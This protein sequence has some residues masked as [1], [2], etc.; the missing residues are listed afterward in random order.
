M[1]PLIRL[2]H[3]KKVTFSV[4]PCP[5]KC[6]SPSTHLNLVMIFGVVIFCWKLLVPVFCR[7]K[8]TNY[9]SDQSAAEFQILFLFSAQPNHWSLFLRACLTLRRVV[10]AQSNLTIYFSILL[11]IRSW[12]LSGKGLA[13]SW[14]LIYYKIWCF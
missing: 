5:Q 6:F 12:R 4:R 10:R 1:V 2:C 3:F 14:N 13:F 7:F 11:K 9:Y 8:N